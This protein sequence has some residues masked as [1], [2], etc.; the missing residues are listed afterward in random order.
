MIATTGGTRCKDCGICSENCDRCPVCG[1]LWVHPLDAIT[2]AVT[3]FRTWDDFTRSMRGGYVPTIYPD[4][5]RKRLLT[6]SVRAAGFRV[7]DGS[8]VA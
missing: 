6:R 8:R 5:R 2:N 4:N 7:Y 1:R 3:A